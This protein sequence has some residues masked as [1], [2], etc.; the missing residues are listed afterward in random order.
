MDSLFDN[1]R[2]LKIISVCISF[3]FILEFHLSFAQVV[4]GPMLGHIELRTAKIW[5]QVDAGSTVDLKFWDARHPQQQKTAFKTVAQRFEFQTQ[6]FDLTGL[7]FNTEYEYQLFSGKK[8]LDKKYGG[9]FIT[10]DLWQYRKPAPDFSF[11][12]G[13]CSYFNEP[14][15]DR[16]NETYGADSLIFLS[17][18]KEPARF[19]VWLGDAWYNREVDYGSEWGLWYRA[20]HDR[21][22]PYMQD[23]YK[24][25]SHYGI[26]D[27]HDFGPNNQGSSYIFKESS[28][29]VFKNYFAN[30]SYGFDGKGI[31]TKLSYSDVDIFLLDNRTWR[32]ADYLNAKIDNL[33]NPEKRMFG[34]M[35]M[36]W[37]KNALV[38]SY[39]TFKIIATGS[40]ILNQMSWND[41]M[42]Y[43]PA[44]F[45]E[46]MT[47]LSTQKINGVVF[48]TGDR[49]HSEIIQM[50][51]D[52]LYTLYDITVSS[53]TS[54]IG[55][56]T[57]TKEFNNPDRVSETLL[58]DYNYGRFSFTGKRKERFM[59][60]EFVDRKGVVQKTWS[61]SENDLR[62]PYVKRD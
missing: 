21:A 6:V 2:M 41:C 54:G 16:P 8:M 52:S 59:K 20:S 12:T 49:H 57:G 3:V 47:F 23:L 37:L 17:L 27:D 26:W 33:P 44:E 19:M 4:S 42:K 61:I 10:N 28:R 32:S 40:Q 36:D 55:K 13:S 53:L 35:Q 45:N 50:K 9:K 48:L 5:V 46:L 11:V 34:K 7:D 39:A 18:T 22:L 60:V 62:W 43:Y 58:E 30:P 25:Y 51:R 14:I 29:E 1:K 56:V 38:E 31:F 24:S 15:Y